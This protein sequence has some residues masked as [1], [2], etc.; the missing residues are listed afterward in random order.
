M[1]AAPPLPEVAAEPSRPPRT[2]VLVVAAVLSTLIVRALV[3]WSRLD[4]LELERYSAS[5]GWALL[6]GVELNPA[7]LPIIPHLRGSVVF[8]VLLVPLLAVG[9]PTLLAVKVLALAFSAVTAGLTAH[10]AGRHLGLRAGVCA[11]LLL[12]F[13]PPAFQ[14]V[15]VLA[16]GSHADAIPF[17]LAPL[18]VLLAAPG[19][20]PL[21]PRACLGLGVLLGA[22]LFFSMQVWV[23]L[24]ALL[25]A[26]WCR[27]R[28]F[29][30]RPRA[31]LTA[32]GAAPFVALIPVVT[33]SAT[34]VN[35]PIEER[36]VPG[37]P[38]SVP[39]KYVEAL[40]SELPRSW[41]YADVGASWAMWVVGLACAAGAV[42]VVV[43][44][45]WRRLLRGA[46][47]AAAD[48]LGLYA[49]VHVAML[50]GAYAV[51][52][53]R[54][55][56]EAT[57][58]GMGSRYFLPIVPA[59]CLLVAAG[60]ARL[61]RRA[62]Q[63]L[64]ALV[65][66]AG[67]AGVA[68]L[69]DLSVG[70]GQPPVLAT[71]IGLFHDHVAH[72][73]PDDPVARLELIHALDPNWIG[74]QPLLHNSSFAP[75]EAVTTES[76]VRLLRA[77]QTSPPPV[78][79]FQLRILGFE[80]ARVAIESGPAAPDAIGD[81]LVALIRTG[82]EEVH[83]GQL[84]WF[85]RGVGQRISIQQMAS[86]KLRPGRV[87]ADT[88]A[89]VAFGF[90]LLRNV[91]RAYRTMVIEGM[92]F[93]VGMRLTPYER[94]VLAVLGSAERLASPFYDQYFTAAAWGFRTRF[95]EATFRPDAAFSVIPLLAER[96]RPAFRN[97]LGWQ[98]PLTP[99]APQTVRNDRPRRL[100]I[101][102]DTH[103]D[104]H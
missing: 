2:R 73:E 46:P 20:G 89:A 67:L 70:S 100:S 7:K 60:V 42:A 31:A 55:N 25:A 44:F 65:A 54:V 29:A 14:M 80:G 83:P 59:L 97:G 78:A 38:W 57:L 17:V 71:E 28:R 21:S 10:L 88:A 76:L 4:E 104:G 45:P 30:L 79:A 48:V 75:T 53:F 24:P 6:H 102:G 5:F 92:G 22:G 69:L 56:L 90:D 49:L 86:A 18:A 61:P 103:H 41:L 3:A 63:G 91:P 64:T 77:A 34:L 40:T 8:G 62:G 50:L 81:R 101:A 12:A 36:F 19:R 39:G 9:G 1:P 27:D 23:A 93:Q 95:V 68:P 99:L 15:D 47:P 43:G 98:G 52:D 96:A 33:R 16:L 37:F 51:S 11:A 84:I 26:W 74:S 66:A 58:D 13:A 35:R 72:A 85:L 82:A 87:P 32:I 94:R